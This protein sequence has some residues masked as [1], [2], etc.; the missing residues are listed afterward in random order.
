MTNSPRSE[1][2]KALPVPCYD[3]L[4]LDHDEGRIAESGAPGEAAKNVKC[5]E[6][7]TEVLTEHTQL[8]LLMQFGISNRHK[9]ERRKKFDVTD[10]IRGVTR[11]FPT[12]VSPSIGEN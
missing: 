2:S 1:K 12:E 11:C 5:A 9:S 3:G 10:S 4:R 6:R 8:H 7:E